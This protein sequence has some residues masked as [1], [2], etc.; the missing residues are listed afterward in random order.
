MSNQGSEIDS[1]G[2]AN[3]FL[4]SIQRANYT[5]EQSSAYNST[6]ELQQEIIFNQPEIST[7]PES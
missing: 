5:F 3:I 4:E 7:A 2:E 1:D 6:E